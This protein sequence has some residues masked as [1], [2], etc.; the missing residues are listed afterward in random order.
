MNILNK[1]YTEI[2]VLDL[3]PYMAGENGALEELGVQVRNIQETIG[4]W[5]VINHGVAW[6][7]LEETYKQL[8]QFFAL[9]DNEKRRYLIN[10]L[11]IGYVPPKSTKYITSIINEKSFSQLFFL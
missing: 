10:E 2:P 8:K 11:S 5:A 7:K 3:G 4:F 1:V 9:S 6:K